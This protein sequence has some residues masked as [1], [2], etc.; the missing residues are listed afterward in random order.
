MVKISKKSDSKLVD[1][2]ESDEKLNSGNDDGVDFRFTFTSDIEYY[3][4]IF[5]I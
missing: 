2:S 5:I 3:I 4:N 1:I